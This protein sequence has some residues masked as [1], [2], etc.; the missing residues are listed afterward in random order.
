MIDQM[1]KTIG[2]L[3]NRVL[4]KIVLTLLLAAALLSQSAPGTSSLVLSARA[5]DSPP[6]AASKESGAVH[7]NAPDEL[8]VLF[9][10]VGKADAALLRCN[11]KAWL[12]DTGSK[13]SVPALLGALALFHVKA[14]EGVFLTHGHSDHTGGMEALAG[15]IPIRTLYSSVFS[16]DK[17]NGENRI[18]ELARDLQLTQR[19]LSAGSNIALTQDVFL[20]VLGPVMENPED[21][22]DNSLVL[23][24]RANGRTLLFAGDMQQ[25]GEYALLRSG[26]ALSADI[27][28]VGN[29]GNPD[30]TSDAFAAAVSPGYAVISTDTLEDRDS[31]NERVLS[32]LG[33]AQV[34]ITQS[35]ACGVL[36]T[37]R[38]DGSIEV[39]Y[40][41]L[42]KAPANIL[43]QGVNRDTQTLTIKNMGPDAD[44]S[45]FIIMS[46]RGSEV[47]VFPDG[48]H[49]RSGQLARVSTRPGADYLW[50]QVSGVWHRQK[51]DSALL[52]DRFGL[53]L[54]R[55]D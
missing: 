23:K 51:E 25:T 31:A 26:A 33:E 40:P 42:P 21:D 27:L 3:E 45:G 46:A 36:M 54:S 37:L 11:G 1:K 16:Q 24:L 12:I 19:K 32:A 34:F 13:A 8:S 7:E 2:K 22:N 50:P 6:A 28:K 49:L 43:V 17:K 5:A 38:T 35:Y 15:Y 55:Y 29:H 9:I 47:F 39:S 44:I 41:A 4:K 48:S 52:F 14:L 53:L 20:E 10:N 18:D 30:A